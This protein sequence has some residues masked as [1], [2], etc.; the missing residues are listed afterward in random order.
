M[1]TK[2]IKVQNAVRT[3]RWFATPFML[4]ALVITA[5]CG[6]SKKDTVATNPGTVTDPNTGA[7]VTN[8]NSITQV[9]STTAS[10]TPSG[11]S[12][13]TPAATPSSLS[14][15]AGGNTTALP[16]VL[17]IT[18]QNNTSLADPN[19][20]NKL[21]AFDFD[22]CDFTYD[23]GYGQGTTV[24]SHSASFYLINNTPGAAITA[25]T[26]NVGDAPGTQ[27]VKVEGST[28]A[29]NGTSTAGAHCTANYYAPVSGTVTITAVPA[30]TLD[31]TRATPGFS[32]SVNLT[33]AN[34]ATL[35]GDFNSGACSAGGATAT[36]DSARV[37][38]CTCSL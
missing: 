17:F 27:Y 19:K 6:S 34:G 33:L 21:S 7:T 30:T 25:G 16:T 23:F 22:Y 15:T 26:Y 29:A 5:A 24:P 18:N 14:F 35:S 13:Y 37:A 9:P 4:G 20:A 38:S 1:N 28:V 10:C 36:P 3:S 8:P 31:G 12:K 32:G 11:T 2:N